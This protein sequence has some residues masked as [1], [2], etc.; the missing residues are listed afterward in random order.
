[1]PE[2]PM[3][4]MGRCRARVKLA[5]SVLRKRTKIDPIQH[6]IVNENVLAIMGVCMPIMTSIGAYSTGY[7][8]LDLIGE[9]LNGVVQIYLGALICTENVEFLI[10]K[11]MS[12]ADTE[13]Y[14]I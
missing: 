3:P 14:S 4:F 7:G 6:T 11:S 8:G 2:P 5:Y 12:K 13:V 9:M 1:M 10:G